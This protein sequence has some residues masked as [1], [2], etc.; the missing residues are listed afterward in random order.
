MSLD[1][2]LTRL[3]IH[4]VDRKSNRLECAPQEQIV[5]TLS[6]TIIRF[7]VNLVSQVWSAEE[8]SANRS[9]HFVPDDDP[10]L[11]PIILADHFNEKQQS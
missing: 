6:P 7:F 2:E 1:L 8:K 11:A 5:E 3:A 9:G 10:I 4:Y